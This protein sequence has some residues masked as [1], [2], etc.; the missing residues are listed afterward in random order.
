MDFIYVFHGIR[1]PYIVH[2]HEDGGTLFGDCY[3]QGLTEGEAV[4]KV[5]EG[6][7]KVQTISL[8]W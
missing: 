8:I 4:K 2:E 6:L 7:L 3:V 5:E 1:V